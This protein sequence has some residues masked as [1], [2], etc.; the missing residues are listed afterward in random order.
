MPH[1]GKEVNSTDTHPL[2]ARLWA[3][4]RPGLEGSSGVRSI[5]TVCQRSPEEEQKQ[6][7][8]ALSTGQEWPE[9]EGTE[10]APS[11]HAYP[12]SY[13]LDPARRYTDY[14]A[15]LA[16]QVRRAVRETGIPACVHGTHVALSEG[17]L[18]HDIQLGLVRA[19]LLSHT[20]CPVWTGAASKGARELGF[21]GRPTPSLYVYLMDQSYLDSSVIE[22]AY[23]GL[24]ATDDD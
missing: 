16:V 11:L 21:E 9:Y 17:I 23:P 5:I 19:G 4:V 1:R 12:I 22:S 15:L 24:G 7:E 14:D 18:F 8:I 10:Q 3:R 20:P 13:A 6:R 2:L